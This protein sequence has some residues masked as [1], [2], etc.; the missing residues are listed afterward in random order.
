MFVVRYFVF[1]GGI[2]VGLFFLADWYFPA[3]T[4]AIA[5]NDVDRTIIRIRSSH[6][7]PAAISF[8]TSAPMPMPA[9][10]PVIA[11][12]APENPPVARVRQAY[13]FDPPPQKAPEKIH[14]R[15]K[16]PRPALRESGPRLANY[17]PPDARGWPPAGW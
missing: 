17:Q 7:W 4:A 14:R 13:A 11:E 8:D 9:A 6:K 2:L 12:A 15:V 3:P 10:A 5:A 1:M 16:A